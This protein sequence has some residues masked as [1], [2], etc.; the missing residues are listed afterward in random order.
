MKI[1]SGQAIDILKKNQVV[2]I[3][4]E[5]VYGLAARIGSDLALSQIFETKKRPFFDPL[6]VHVKSIEQAQALCLHWNPIM[7]C[8]AE[9]FWP[10]PLT[11]VVPKTKMVSDLITSG[12]ATVG[13]RCP[14]HAIA[15]DIIEGVGEPLAAPSANLFGQTSPT[16]A[17]HVI[18]EFNNQIPVVDGG[19]CLIGIESTVLLVQN[20]QISILR[21]GQVTQ[22]MIEVALK[23]KHLGFDWTKSVDKKLSPGQMKHHYMPS[24][25]LFGIDSEFK[26]DLIARLNQELSHLPDEVEGVKIHKPT[27]IRSIKELKLSDSACEAARQLYSELRRLAEGPEDALTFYFQ[28]SHSAPDWVAVHERL[29]KACTKFIKS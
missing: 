11:M 28:K 18:S 1:S 15:L 27:Q 13:L 2:A 26:G 5:T 10:G 4:T 24:K 29:S 25:P 16:L 12:L 3:P 7:Q 20:H 22:L 14:Q 17:D 23:K 21:P 6:I 19:P 8:L 9:S